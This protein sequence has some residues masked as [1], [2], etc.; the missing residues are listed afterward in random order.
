MKV[1][2]NLIVLFLCSIFPLSANAID[3]NGPLERIYSKKLQVLSFPSLINMSEIISCQTQF[4]N[5][6]C[7]ELL[8]S[9]PEKD[10]HKIIKCNAAA[11]RDNEFENLDLQECIIGTIKLS[12][13]NLYDLRKVPGTLIDASVKALSS[14]SNCN[15][16]DVKKAEMVKLFNTGISDPKYQFD[17]KFFTQTVP[18]INCGEL[19]QMLEIRKKNY[20]ESHYR[21]AVKQRM[22]SFVEYKLPEDAYKA[23]SNSELPN[24]IKKIFEEAKINYECYTPKAKAEMTCSLITSLIT[25]SATG[26]GMSKGLLAVK[27]IAFGSEIYRAQSNLERFNQAKLK[28]QSFPDISPKQ[29]K[30]SIEFLS[31]DNYSNVDYGDISKCLNSCIEK[32]KEGSNYSIVFTPDEVSPKVNKFMADL[33]KSHTGEKEIPIEINGEKINRIIVGKNTD[34]PV[35]IIGRGHDRVL[36]IQ[37]GMKSETFVP[38]RAAMKLLE[39]QNDLSLMLEENRKWIISV[40]QRGLTIIDLGQ[41]TSKIKSPFYETELSEVSNYLNNINSN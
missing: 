6:N 3:C 38:S 16:D 10:K 36:S 4:Q 25:D 28:S 2:L 1:I 20:Y 5:F 30:Q 40:R 37:A 39:E 32:V 12:A 21:K 26:F 8:G 14:G 17:Q 19:Q 33:K 13:Q 23:D 15:D 7:K 22:F 34:A 24:Q 11:I 41:G 27:K 31:K 35:A 9:L 29:R 18:R